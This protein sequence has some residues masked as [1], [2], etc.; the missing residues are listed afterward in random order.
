M[1][2]TLHIQQRDH[3][4]YV[5]VSICRVATIRRRLCWRAWRVCRGWLVASERSGREWV[6][7]VWT[8]WLWH[9]HLWHTGVVRWHGLCGIRHPVSGRYGVG[10]VRVASRNTGSG[11]RMWRLRNTGHRCN[12]RRGCGRLAGSGWS[13]RRHRSH[14]LE[15]FLHLF[16]LHLPQPV[17]GSL[18][19][20]ASY[21]SVAAHFRQASHISV[22]HFLHSIMESTTLHHPTLYYIHMY[23][24]LW[25]LQH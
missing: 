25:L 21:K 5:L 11:E 6:S 9:G 16:C 4:I 22:S 14:V 17:E 1:Y 3:A 19:M 12:V 23:K 15:K 8:L 24:H 2:S 20:K 7:L 18:L 10:R 13:R